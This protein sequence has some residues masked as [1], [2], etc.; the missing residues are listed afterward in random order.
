MSRSLR[1]DALASP[2]RVLA[3]RLDDCVSVIEIFPRASCYALC[4]LNIAGVLAGLR[5]WLTSGVASAQRLKL[6]K[7]LMRILEF[8]FDD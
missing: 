6:K 2:W 7:R 8:W 1:V 3:A 5:R 4:M